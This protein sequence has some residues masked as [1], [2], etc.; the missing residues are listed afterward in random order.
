MQHVVAARADRA[1]QRI[2]CRRRAGEDVDV[3]APCPQHPAEG[4]TLV[5]RAGQVE[6]R[7]DHHQHPQA[8]VGLTLLA[9]ACHRQRLAGV[10]ARQSALEGGVHV[11]DAQRFPR[12]A[13]SLGVVYH[14]QRP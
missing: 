4:R 13:R 11:A 5:G 3:G 10:T 14:H 12:D 1:Q 7:V 9:P 6:R 8:A 2:A